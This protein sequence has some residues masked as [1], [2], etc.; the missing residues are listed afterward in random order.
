MIHLCD[1]WDCGEYQ[2][3]HGNPIL[4]LSVGLKPTVGVNRRLTKPF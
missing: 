4:E 1:V 3:H 2:I